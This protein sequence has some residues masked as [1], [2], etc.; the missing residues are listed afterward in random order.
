MAESSDS[1]GDTLPAPV[2]AGILRSPGSAPVGDLGP[3]RAAFA[4]SGDETDGRY[5]LTEFIM[6]PPPAQPPPPHIHEDASEAIYVLEGILEMAVGEQRL[7]G[8]AGALM[9]VPKGSLHSLSNAGS[10]PA[11]FL[12]I[13]SPP[14]FEEF[15]RDMAELRAR[16]G[17]SP[18]AETTLALQWKYHLNTSGK[19]RRF[20]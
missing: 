1:A 3:N 11:R 7:T 12:V 19:A 8:S 17:G 6:A 16:L 5:S 20:E 14:G 18:D 15:W 4:L 10:G 9:F 13:L 2:S